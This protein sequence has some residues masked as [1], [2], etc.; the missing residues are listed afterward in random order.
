[1][2]SSSVTH[3]HSFRL[4]LAGLNEGRPFGTLEAWRRLVAGAL[5]RSGVNPT[6]GEELVGE[7]QSELFVRLLTL[8]Q[9]RSVAWRQLLALE[10]RL[11]QAQ[12][13]RMAVRASM[14]LDPDR[15]RKRAL[16]QLVGR[17]LKAGLP[18]AGGP[19]VT[20]RKGG[21]LHRPSVAAAVAWALGRADGPPARP[22]VIACWLLRAYEPT[23]PLDEA[24]PSLS[25]G[26]FDGPAR[27]AEHVEH[28]GR[29]TTRLRSRLA[30]EEARALTL[31]LQ[32]ETLEEI[33]IELGCRRTKAQGLAARAREEAACVVA[34]L[35]AEW[36]LA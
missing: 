2:R 22:Y 34:E 25:A 11:L 3:I 15:D 36:K 26:A 24:E 12:L 31:H 16:A 35:E 18:P 4:A 14:D 20:L 21:R 33:A 13:R 23:S 32:G 7:V 17:L 5:R 29:V 1:M 8:R 9:A 19:P 10:E 6:P 28:A 27:S 30:P